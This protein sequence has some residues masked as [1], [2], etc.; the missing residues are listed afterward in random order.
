V[1]IDR[2]QEREWVRQNNLANAG[3][4]GAAL[5]MVQPFLTAS[6]LDVAAKICVVAFAVAIPLLAALVLVGQQ[7]TFRQQP[8]KSVLVSL[9]KP[10]A[11]GSWFLGIVAGFWNITWIAGVAMLVVA[12]IALGV[13]SAGYWRLER[14]TSGSAFATVEAL[15]RRQDDKA[16]EIRDMGARAVRED[17]QFSST[18]VARV[19]EIQAEIERIGRDIE[20]LLDTRHDSTAPSDE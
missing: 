5:I 1:S 4:I 7:E 10:V 17:R 20:A 15:R 16:R 14:E 13:H 9:A 12:L 11:Q 2:A 19:E 6:R 3:L 8:T 18:E